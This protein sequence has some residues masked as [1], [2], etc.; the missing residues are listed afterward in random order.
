LVGLEERPLWRR[1]VASNASRVL[2][3]AAGTGIVTRQ[4][5]ELLPGERI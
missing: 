5:R 1:L 4:I 2:E 3:T